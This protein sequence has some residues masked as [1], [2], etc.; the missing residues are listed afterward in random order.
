MV[1][2]EKVLD[3]ISGVASELKLTKL[4]PQIAACR[5]QFNGSK[6]IEVAVLGRFKAGKSSFLNSL[7]GRNVLPIGVLPVT[8]V[9]TRLRHGPS[10]KAEV[11]FRNGTGRLIPLEEVNLYV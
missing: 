6:G 2:V 7:T 8:T 9:V 3:R 5:R 1:A 10:E 11:R 4:E